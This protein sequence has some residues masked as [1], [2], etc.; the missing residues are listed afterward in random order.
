MSTPIDETNNIIARSECILDTD[1]DYQA[2][3]TPR[4]IWALA[5]GKKVVTTN[6]NIVKIPFYNNKNIFIID[7]RNPIINPNFITSKA[8]DMSSVMEKYRIDNWVKILLEQ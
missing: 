2:G 1:I 7:R 8:D 4:L 3:P 6:K 5:L